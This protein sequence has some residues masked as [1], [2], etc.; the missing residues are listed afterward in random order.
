MKN[1][2]MIASAFACGISAVFMANTSLADENTKN[3]NRVVAANY[4]I[5]QAS[6]LDKKT[7]GDNVRASQLMGM[8]IYNSQ[9]KSVAEINDIVLDASSGKVKYAAV[10]YGGFLGV[11]NKMFAVPFQAFKV[12]Q[13]KEDRDEYLLVLNVTEKQLEGA[14]GFDE[15]HWPSFADSKFTHELDHRYKVKRKA[16]KRDLSRSK[17]GELDDKTTGTNVRFSQMSGMNIY[18]P[19]GKSVGEIKDIVLDASSGKIKYAAVTYGGFLGVGN[20]MFAVPFQAFKVQQ[21]KEDRDEYLLVLNVTEKELDGANG[22]DEEHWP[23]FADRKFNQELNKR[24]GVE[25]KA[26]RTNVKVQ[27]K[28]NN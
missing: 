5:T 23:N 3:Q 11:G 16:E 15:E 24:Y 25:I 10:T 12:Q 28:L 22:F 9:G 13:N 6:N 26:G 21:N 14:K 1:H 19:Q 17:A 8:N 7:F 4:G 2:V 18:N 20:K 27:P